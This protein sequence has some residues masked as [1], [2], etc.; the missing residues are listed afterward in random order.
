VDYRRYAQETNVAWEKSRQEIEDTLKRYRCTHFGYMT[1]P[2][3]V[4]IGFTLNKVPY[5][6]EVPLPDPKS[7]PILYKPN[8]QRRTERMIETAVEQETRRRWRV[9]L[10]LIKAKL[11]WVELG[12][13][14][15]E[16]EFMADIVLPDG[17]TMIQWASRQLQPAIEAGRM[18]TNILSLPEAS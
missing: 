13:S 7:K 5:R 9:L 1:M 17:T 2:N 18:P 11:E 3:A 16:K 6:L 14:T 4:M 12:M 15:V 8:G 10:L